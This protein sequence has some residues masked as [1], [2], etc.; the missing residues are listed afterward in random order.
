LSSV[1]FIGL[2]VEFPDPEHPARAVARS[3][4]LAL[5]DRLTNLAERARP[6]EGER[7]GAQLALILDGMY[8]N[9]AHLGPDGPAGTGPALAVA[10]LERRR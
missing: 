6:G 1:Y 8:V 5:R 3:Y 4:R 7:I 10:V 9:A 2:N